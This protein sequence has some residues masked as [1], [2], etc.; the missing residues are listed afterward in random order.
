M[1]GSGSPA[2]HA[3]SANTTTMAVIFIRHSWR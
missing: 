3:A 2:A 1:G